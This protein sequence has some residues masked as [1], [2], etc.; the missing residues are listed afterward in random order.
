MFYKIYYKDMCTFSTEKHSLVA[1]E[2]FKEP[3]TPI[4][5]CFTGPFHFVSQY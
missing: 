5:T 3:M 4:K 1:L 2:G